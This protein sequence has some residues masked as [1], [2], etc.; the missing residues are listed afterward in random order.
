MR[1]RRP[2]SVPATEGEPGLLVP[3]RHVVLDADGP[4][5]IA[6]GRTG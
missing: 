1:L 6:P 4:V 2:N 3:R 5:S